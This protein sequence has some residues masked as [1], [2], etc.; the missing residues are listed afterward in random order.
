MVQMD[1]LSGYIG[2]QGSSIVNEVIKTISNQFIFFHEKFLSVQKH[3]TSKNELTN[4]KI[5][6]QKTT[7]ATI[8]LCAQKLLRG[9]KIFVCVLG[10]FVRSKF[11]CKKKTKKNKLEIVLITSFA[12]LLTCTPTNPSIENYFSTNFG[13]NFV[14]PHFYLYTLI[15]ICQNLFSMII[16]N[17]FSKFILIFI[18]VHLFLI[19]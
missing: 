6:E 1:L 18:C 19:V 4:Q 17:L 7:K 11:F 3:V 8:L 9:W 5:N 13:T 2:M 10:L 16:L 12:I 15:F 14:V